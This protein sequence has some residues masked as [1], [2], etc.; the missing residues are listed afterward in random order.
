MAGLNSEIK[1]HGF[2]LHIQTQDAGAKAHYVETLV[3]STGQLLFSRK[4][5]YAPHLNHLDLEEKVQNLVSDQHH[6]I[7]KQI[8]EGKF[9]HFLTSKREPDSS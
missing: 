1:H 6:Q 3:Y 9:D 4:T 2:S 7:I 5:S 8:R